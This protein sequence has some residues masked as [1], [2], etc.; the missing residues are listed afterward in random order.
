MYDKFIENVNNLVYVSMDTEIIYQIG[1]LS[2]TFARLSGRVW[3]NPKLTILTMLAAYR[4]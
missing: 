4:A 3:N 2:G 1:K